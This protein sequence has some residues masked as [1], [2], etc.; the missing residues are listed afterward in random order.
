[1]I[2]PKTPVATNF[3]P[4]SHCR[5]VAAAASLSYGQMRPVTLMVKTQPQCVA[6]AGHRQPVFIVSPQSIREQT[7][8]PMKPGMTTC[9]SQMGFK[10]SA[11]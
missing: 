2:Q 9:Q 11:M 5:P 1:M 10:K 6:I 4:K 8:S 7:K 3:S